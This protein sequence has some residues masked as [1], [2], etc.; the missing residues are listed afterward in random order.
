MFL[1]L[2]HGSGV[3]PDGEHMQKTALKWMLLLYLFLLTGFEQ[4]GLPA[5]RRGS[6]NGSFPVGATESSGVSGAR[7]LV[8]R[9][10]IE[11]AVKRGVSVPFVETISQ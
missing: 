2:N 7:L 4:E 5:G 1:A 8:G 10:A 11:S 9:G 6:G 3:L